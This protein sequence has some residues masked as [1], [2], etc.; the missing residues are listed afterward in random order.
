[1]LN[2]TLSDNARLAAQIQLQN[3]RVSKAV[4]A[5]ITE[6]HCGGLDHHEVAKHTNSPV[7]TVR[8]VLQAR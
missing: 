5:C 3:R 1:M 4:I 2:T 8:L 7:D 6:L